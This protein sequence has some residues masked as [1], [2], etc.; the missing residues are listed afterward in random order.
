[1]SLLFLIILEVVNCFTNVCVYKCEEVMSE[2]L[3]NEILNDYFEDN[4][5]ISASIK[6]GELYGVVNCNLDPNSDIVQPGKYMEETNKTLKLKYKKKSKFEKG[7]LKVKEVYC[8]HHDTHYEKTRNASI[9]YE[10][11]PFSRFRNT[12]CPFRITFKVF[13]ITERIFL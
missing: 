9:V 10:K 12:F 2:I 1:M 3:L 6:E 7:N 13:K 5:E 8:W 4:C 11:K